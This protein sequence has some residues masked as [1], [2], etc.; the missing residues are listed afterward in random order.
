ML[1]KVGKETTMVRDRLGLAGSSKLVMIRILPTLATFIGFLAAVVLPY[2]LQYAEP[3]FAPSVINGINIFEH[4]H[5]IDSSMMNLAQR[6]LASDLVAEESYPLPGMLT[7]FLLAITR[8]PYEWVAYIP[9]AGIGSLLY[10]V[11]GKYVLS[12]KCNG[13]AALLAVTYFWLNLS[14]RLPALTTGRACLGTIVLTLFV[15][16]YLRLLESPGGKIFPWLIICL[17]VTAM[18]GG[19]YYTATLAIITIG[20]ISFVATQ[21]RFQF[22]SFE[23]FSLPRGFSIFV[24]A[25][26]LFFL[27]PVL[28]TVAPDLSLQEGLRNVLD[29]IRAKIGLESTEARNLYGI[30]LETNFT[31]QIRLW[32]L[33]V[34]ILLSLFSMVLIV[35]S[36]I[37]KP[38]QRITRQ[39]LYAIVAVGVCCSELPYIF[40]TPTIPTRF[41]LSFGFLCT[42]CVVCHS[43]RRKIFS[44]II[45]ALVTIA[46]LSSLSF[47]LQQGGS[48]AAKPFAVEKI[49]PLANYLCRAISADSVAADACYASNLWLFL[50][51]EK[52]NSE[53]TVLPFGGDALLLKEAQDGSATLLV[54]VLKRRDISYLLINIDGMPFFG[55]TWG[56]AVNLHPG[57]RLGALP[58]GLIFDDGRFILCNIPELH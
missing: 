5:M 46:V 25:T 55:D 32:S 2:Y 39:W 58:L 27:P 41:L 15:L 11:L 9:I 52:K 17:I 6:R 49:Q 50:A 47:S 3:Y 53:V 35:V 42:L 34:I 51:D 48:L 31:N 1:L 45:I 28:A 26:L 56:Y 24:T 37:L 19:T 10:F 8:L 21:K 33:R 16:S 44:S 18:A 22:T 14:N 23:T 12:N 30:Y 20:I 43:G 7:A 4:G 40:E 38:E 36:G 57:K 13:Y 54:K 29:A